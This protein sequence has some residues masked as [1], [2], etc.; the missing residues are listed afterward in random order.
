MMY[1]G[2]F[3]PL[4]PALVAVVCWR[5]LPRYARL[6]GG[7][8]VLVAINSLFSSY[9]AA[10]HEI[11]NLPFYHGYILLQG[12]VLIAV[13]R[14]LLGDSLPQQRWHAAFWGFALAWLVNVIW[15]DTLFG[16]PTHI[17]TL[18]ALLVLALVIRWYL[19]MLNERKIRQPLRHPGFWLS[20]GLLLYFSGNLL[21]YVFTEVVYAGSQALFQALWGPHAVLSAL[22]DVFFCGVLWLASKEDG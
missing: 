21:L 15:Y 20:T 9:L 7:A 18:E 4:L 19:K 8:L 1:I 3:T 2:V 14:T 17:Q 6:L 5:K 12:L 16:F 10:V 11:N 13:Y 22:L